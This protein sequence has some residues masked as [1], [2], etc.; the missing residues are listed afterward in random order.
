VPRKVYGQLGSIVAADPKRR[1]WRDQVWMTVGDRTPSPHSTYLGWQLDWQGFEVNPVGDRPLRRVAHY[2]SQ[3]RKNW[4]ESL[5]RY[6]WARLAVSRPRDSA[7]E[8]LRRRPT[9]E[10]KTKGLQGAAHLLGSAIEL[11]AQDRLVEIPYHYMRARFRHACGD[12]TGAEEDWRLL[13]AI[14]AWQ[15]DEPAISATWPVQVPRVMPLMHPYE[16]G[17]VHLLSAA[18]EDLLQGSTAWDGRA[19]RIAKAR[20]LLQ[21]VKQDYF[22]AK[23]VHWDLEDWL[24]RVNEIDTK[25]GSGVDLPAPIFTS[26]E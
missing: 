3:G 17:L 5:A 8:L 1:P 13:R 6:V 15:N 23:R 24:E 2:A 16:A 25:G 14:W 7:G 10:E 26:A 22:G 18:T 21:Q 4:E 9:A 20:V 19:G 11:A 12:Y